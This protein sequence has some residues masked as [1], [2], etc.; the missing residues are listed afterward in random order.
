MEQLLKSLGI[1]VATLLMPIVPLLLLIG[2]AILLDTIFGIMAAKKHNKKIVSTKFSRIVSK[3][4][5][6][7]SLVLL[8]YGMD[9]ILINDIFLNYFKINL[10]FTKIV[11]IGIVVV[12]FFSVDEKIRSLNNNKGTWY[13]FTH[14]TGK[15]KQI[16]HKIKEVK[17]EIKED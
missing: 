2:F 3:S 4:I 15:G 9:Y 1:T 7:M 14:I 8:A 16:A 11:G 12:E 13:Y 17:K 5:V 10:L 6:Y